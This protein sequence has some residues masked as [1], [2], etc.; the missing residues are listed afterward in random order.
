MPNGY[1]Q[2]LC[3]GLIRWFPGS[4]CTVVQGANSISALEIPR[5]KLGS[6]NQSFQR[7]NPHSLSCIPLFV[8]LLLLLLLLVPVLLLL[9]ACF[10]LVNEH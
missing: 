4:W 7:F 9:L 6:T 1:A 2:W 3:D 5:D 8:R 10:T